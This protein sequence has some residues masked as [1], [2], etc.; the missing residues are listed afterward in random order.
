MDEKRDNCDCEGHH[1]VHAHL[2]SGDLTLQ[3][4]DLF[5]SVQPSTVKTSLSLVEA[6][7]VV[8]DIPSILPGGEVEGQVC[9][10]QI[11]SRNARVYVPLVTW[12]AMIVECCELTWHIGGVRSSSRHF[13]ND[14]DWIKD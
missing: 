13:F 2:Q 3:S 8:V 6:T 12:I 11:F 4:L 7:D 5:I 10:G 14:N 9:R 1:D